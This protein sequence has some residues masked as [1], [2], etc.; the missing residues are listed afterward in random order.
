MAEVTDVDVSFSHD[1]ALAHTAVEAVVTDELGR[2]TRVEGKTFALYPF[3][4]SPQVTLNEG[5]MAVTI[6]DHVGVGHVE[7]AWPSDYLAHV[8]GR[9]LSAGSAIRNNF[10]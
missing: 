2:T 1:A 10:V 3:V 7:M 9:D 4:V 5:S 8:G 6:D